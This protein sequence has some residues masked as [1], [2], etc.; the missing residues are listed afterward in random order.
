MHISSSRPLMDGVGN[1]TLRRNE[2]GIL[3]GNSMFRQGPD[4]R[5]YLGHNTVIQD[6][7]FNNKLRENWL[8]QTYNENDVRASAPEAL[9][10]DFNRRVIGENHS[11]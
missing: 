10:Q 1:N 6:K 5:M 3:A 9:M 7:Q 4:N 2:S 8:Q 11:H